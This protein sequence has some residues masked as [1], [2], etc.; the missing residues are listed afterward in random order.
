MFYFMIIYFFFFFHGP[1]LSHSR[2]NIEVN[3]SLSGSMWEFLWEIYL[4][5]GLLSHSVQLCLYLQV[6]YPPKAHE[7]SVSLNS[8]YMWH[9]P[10]FFFFSN[11]IHFKWYFVVLIS[12]ITNTFEYFFHIVIF[13]WV[14]PVNS[15]FTYFIFLLSF[16]Y[17]LIFGNF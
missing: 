7:N 13:I 15:L 11:M 3:V 17:L 6:S 14:S 2:D 5:A 4:G 8:F 10:I 16:L 9:Y 12:L 1:L